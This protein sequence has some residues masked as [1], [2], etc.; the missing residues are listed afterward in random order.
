MLSV[1][2]NSD[3]IDNFES[4]QKDNLRWDSIEKFFDDN[5]VFDELESC[6]EKGY[7]FVIEVSSSTYDSSGVSCFDEGNDSG[8]DE[9]MPGLNRQTLQQQSQNHRSS[10]HSRQNGRVNNDNDHAQHQHKSHRDHEKDKRDHS[11]SRHRENKNNGIKDT[12]RHT[13]SAHE[14]D[15]RSDSVPRNKGHRSELTVNVKSHKKEN[16][17]M[18]ERNGRSRERRSEPLSKKP[19]PAYEDIKK[20][21]SEPNKRVTIKL[22]S[23]DNFSK[24]NSKKSDKKKSDSNKSPKS[25]PKVVIPLSYDEKKEIN[26]NRHDGVNLQRNN[27]MHIHG[28]KNEIM[29]DTADGKHRVYARSKKDD[30][31]SL[32]KGEDMIDKLGVSPEIIKML[33]EEEK[34][35]Q[36]QQELKHWR[37]CREKQVKINSPSNRDKYAH[38]HMNEKMREDEEDRMAKEARRLM[39]IR[40]QQEQLLKTSKENLLRE[41]N[42]KVIRHREQLGHRDHSD[43]FSFP[44]RVS[45]HPGN[46]G[47]NSTQNSTRSSLAIQ[48]S[49]LSGH[50]TRNSTQPSHT[51]SYEP[52]FKTMHDPEVREQNHRMEQGNNYHRIR[53]KEDVTIP[54][55]EVSVKTRQNSWGNRVK[56]PDRTDAGR[57]SSWNAKLKPPERT[58]SSYLSPDSEPIYERSKR[59]IVGYLQ[60]KP[61]GGCF[62]DNDEIFYEKRRHEKP[63]HEEE[64]NRGYLSD[65]D[66]FRETVAAHTYQ[67]RP[68]FMR[69]KI[70]IRCTACRNVISSEKLMNVEGQNYYWHLKCFFCVVCRAYLND[71]HMIRVRIVNYRLHCRYCYSVQSGKRNL[72]SDFLSPLTSQETKCLYVFKYFN[73]CVHQTN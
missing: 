28:S 15:V 46:Q 13:Q 32:V 16:V 18:K 45:A 43:R 58:A 21:R 52:Y 34:F 62:S 56:S 10:E 23:A 17:E 50:T 49:P 2:N 26:L 37:E 41:E 7:L 38:R 6:T 54:N 59:S 67:A 57:R 3:V 36:K 1:G 60:R 8:I 48:N 42:E 11:S 5:S 27:S 55:S 24:M 22:D 14:K 68:F 71:Q 12:S 33:K 25:G 19:P 64:D 9:T 30:I 44:P 72:L 61:S 31:G 53:E 73:F 35:W 69:Q 47:Q 29:W 70:N 40:A 4:P 63:S 39:R 20:R 66:V 65:H 51:Q